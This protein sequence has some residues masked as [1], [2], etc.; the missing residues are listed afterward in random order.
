MTRAFLLVGTG[1]AAVLFIG[2]IAGGPAIDWVTILFIVAFPAVGIWGW[3]GMS[4]GTAELDQRGIRVRA[5]MQSQTYPWEDIDSIEATTFEQVDKLGDNT[6]ILRTLGVDMSHPMVLI[7]LKR[8]A[9][10][11]WFLSRIGTREF[12]Y[13]MGLKIT[14]E[15][16]DVAGFVKEANRFLS[17]RP[18]EDHSFQNSQT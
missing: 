17:A 6:A 8:S 3:R 15:P 12:G 16:E 18:T 9:R 13:R 1:L 4:I 14:F 10:N 5:R 7:V 2:W 11:H